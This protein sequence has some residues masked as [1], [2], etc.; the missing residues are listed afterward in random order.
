M[1]VLGIQ[2]AATV[3]NSTTERCHLEDYV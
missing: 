2:L 1:A 3:V